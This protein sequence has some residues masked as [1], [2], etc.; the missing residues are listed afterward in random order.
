M[1]DEKLTDQ[2]A[3]NL[4]A[5]Y[6]ELCTS[7]RAIDDFRAKLLGF[8]PLVS[9]VGVFLLLNDAFTNQTA[10]NFARQFLG[11]M[12]I[13]GFVVALGL[14]FYELHGIRKCDHLIRIG[15]QIEDLLGIEGQFTNRPDAV[16]RHI[17]EPF[18]ARVIYPTVL[19]AWTFLASV[20]T[21]HQAALVIAI[22]VFIAGFYVPSRLNLKG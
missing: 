10:S 20:F 2:Q 22:L 5:A 4:R 15:K 16:A 19:A 1:S 13:F 6:Q 21:L 18:T 14:F 3:N 8:L 12:G 9:G 7:Y 11:P 17:N